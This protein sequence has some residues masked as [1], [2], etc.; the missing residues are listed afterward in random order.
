[1]PEND[2]ALIEAASCADA[3]LLAWGNWGSWLERDRAVLNL[4]TPF[5][6]QYRCLGRN[7]TGQ[8]RHPLYVPQSISL[9]PWRES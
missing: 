9:Q 4:L 6:T 5:H 7:R 2:A 3:I 8:P 1:G